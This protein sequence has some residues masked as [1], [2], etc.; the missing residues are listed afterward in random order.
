[1]IADRKIIRRLALLA[2]FGLAGCKR[3]PVE[4][5]KPTVYAQNKC[6][7]QP[8]RRSNGLE[9]GELVYFNRIVVAPE[10]T[11]WNGSGIKLSNLLEYLHQVRTMD[12][13]PVTVLVVKPYSSCSTVYVIRRMMEASLHCSAEKMCV[14]YSETKWG[15][16]HRPVP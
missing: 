10:V 6:G 4:Q 14:E 12:S 5:P 7:G 3:S 16:A 2:L 11:T 15:R 8:R 1:M 9:N 13:Q